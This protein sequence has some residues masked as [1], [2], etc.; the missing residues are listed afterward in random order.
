MN[1]VYIDIPRSALS[2]KKKKSY[3]ES[4]ALLLNQNSIQM[5]FQ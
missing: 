4:V 1:T 5:A 2:S 3:N